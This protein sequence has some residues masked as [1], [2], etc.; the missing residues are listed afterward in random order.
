V[1][2]LLHIGR[3]N[4]LL[5]WNELR[6]LRNIWYDLTGHHGRD[7]TEVLEWVPWRGNYAAVNQADNAFA[8]LRH[9]CDVSESKDAAKRC[10]ECFLSNEE[11]ARQ[12]A[13]EEAA[14]VA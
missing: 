8:A 12:R 11:N 5:V 9:Y 4:F 14:K 1:C 10:L 2:G 7:G 6:K 3:G 13:S